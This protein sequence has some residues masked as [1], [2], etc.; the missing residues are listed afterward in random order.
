M[1][2]K[3]AAG[4]LLAHRRSQR[5]M[6]AWQRTLTKRPTRYLLVIFGNQV[7]RRDA[8]CRTVARSTSL[9]PV[10]VAAPQW[11]LMPLR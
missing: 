10:I 11:R 5:F 7:Q 2:A 3:H 9:I 8:Q 4:H 1:A 6:S